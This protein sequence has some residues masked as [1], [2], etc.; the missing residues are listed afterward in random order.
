MA[1]I[2][3][4]SARM[5][6]RV[7]SLVALVTI[8]SAVGRGSEPA[9]RRPVAIAATRELVFIA[10]QRTGS[11]STIDTTNFEL[12]GEVRLGAE[13]TDIACSG[14]DLLALD[15][16]SR[17]L[18]RASGDPL[19][20]VERLDLGRQPS[21]LCVNAEG[22]RALIS[23][24]WSREILLAGICQPESNSP[25]T[26]TLSVLRRT[27]LPFSP[28]EI[29]AIP[30]NGGATGF[31]VADA[32]RGK[33]ALLDSN[34]TVVKP[35]T[36]SGHNIRGL[37]V[38]SE[39]DTVLIS[40]QILYGDE[41]TTEDNIFWGSVIQ[42]VVRTLSLDQITDLECE[43]D[44]SLNPLSLGRPSDATGDPG[45]VLINN[46]TT[47]IALSGVHQVAFR[48]NPTQP[49]VRIDVGRRPVDLVAATDGDWIASV[50]R[51][52]D[53][54][55]IIDCESKK[56]VR[57]V[58]L[59]PVRK[60]DPWEM[61]EEHFYDARLS[62]DGWYSCHSCHTD[63][64]T[65]GLLNDNLGD[66]SFGAPKRILTLGGVRDTGPWAWDGHVQ[67]LHDQVRKSIEI[68]MRGTKP[69]A[70][71]VG[72]IVAYLN[73]L[74]PA[75]P[76]IET[77]IATTGRSAASPEDRVLESASPRDENG[78][79]ADTSDDSSALHYESP[80]RRSQKAQT[81][82]NLV[83][84]DRGRKLFA[85]L[86]CINCHAPPTYTSSAVY[87]V[88]LA[89][90]RG[91]TEFN[92]PSLRGV[93]QRPRLFHDGRAQGLDAVLSTFRHQLD[94]QLTPW[95]KRDLI[96]FLSTL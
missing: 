33:L 12:R 55:S 22:T 92:P 45:S 73:H 67:R 57:T 40:H 75:P 26:S 64:H 54:V 5:A 72:E 43:V 41:Q 53:S 89:D 63:G 80:T 66:R 9:L 58:S 47:A 1:N 3:E 74:E 51:F 11:V 8:L 76:L 81:P 44:I 20:I 61:G 24:P 60:K 79:T 28:G 29:V 2:S 23:L 87:D 86:G 88:G 59:G 39:R 18:V 84:L 95:E 36:I 37:A 82:I 96:C 21:R 7:A 35:L 78:P 62:L 13:L 6:A 65:N 34:G 90:Q 42:N 91:I 49:F 48:P 69:S 31:L 52:S 17:T 25:N 38:D 70:Q 27:P 32:F 93:S 46:Q 15:P 4:H 77:S 10:N 16:A 71:V 14:D 50:N 56:L 68:T 30:F 94:R 85:T 83:S 19:V